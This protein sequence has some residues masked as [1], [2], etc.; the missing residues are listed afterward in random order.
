MTTAN[1]NTRHIDGMIAQATNPAEA[2]RLTDLRDRGAEFSKRENRHS[3]TCSGWW[4]DG[5]WLGKTTRDAMQAI[6][7]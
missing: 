6:N 3:E 2:A 1:L 7:G 5:V 4:L